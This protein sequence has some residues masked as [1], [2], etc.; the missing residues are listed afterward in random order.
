MQIRTTRNTVA[1]A[2]V[3]LALS[4]ISA[5]GTAN[6]PELTIES[7]RVSYADLNLNNREDAR[8][9]Y[10]RLR[11]AAE[12]VCDVYERQPVREMLDARDCRDHALDKAVREVGSKQLSAIHQG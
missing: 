7:V 9:L 12:N 2:A 4:G 1:A 11:N 6:I 8:T 10:A 5:I 3:F